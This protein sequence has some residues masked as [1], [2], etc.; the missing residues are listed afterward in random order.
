MSHEPFRFVADQ[1]HVAVPPRDLP[2]VRRNLERLGVTLHDTTS[3]P[4]RAG[5]VLHAERVVE[6]EVS[7]ERVK[8]IRLA[9]A[10]RTSLSSFQIEAMAWADEVRES[11]AALAPAL[12]ESSSGAGRRRPK[13]R[14]E[15][16]WLKV[17]R[18]DMVPTGYELAVYDEPDADRQLDLL[19]T[20]ASLQRTE[21]TIK[22][23]PGWE[24]YGNLTV[25]MPQTP[26]K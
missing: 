3:A 15:R 19:A 17:V 14:S 16:I 23:K 1:L 24:G 7:A 4:A 8:T 18:R 2:T 26:R 21:T 13:R 5:V 22:P 12:L 6:I 10:Q 25:F 9:K 11:L 20:V